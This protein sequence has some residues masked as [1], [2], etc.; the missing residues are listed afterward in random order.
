MHEIVPS[1]VD[2]SGVLNPN[3]TLSERD[4]Y[5]I[6][7]PE[8]KCVWLEM[9]RQM[10]CAAWMPAFKCCRDERIY[11]DR[12]F[13]HY[14]KCGKKYAVTDSSQEHIFKL[15]STLFH[16]EIQSLVYEKGDTAAQE[17]DKCAKLTGL[18]VFVNS[19]Q[20]RELTFCNAVSSVCQHNNKI[21][22]TIDS[23]SVAPTV[24]E[25]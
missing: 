20:L 18:L 19:K 10:C 25:C 13:V 2:H 4:Y 14:I 15:F 17:T 22:I 6:M 3:G 1:E 7:G 5:L 23:C 9:S 21:R 12:I 11:S 16:N 8:V 24:T